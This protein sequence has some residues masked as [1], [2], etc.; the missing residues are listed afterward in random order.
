MRVLITIFFLSL[1][2]TKG[3]CGDDGGSGGDVYGK[4]F[5][6]LGREFSKVIK[7]F[8]GSA[9]LRKW[10]VDADLFLAA[11]EATLL[12]SDEGE[13]VVLKGKEVDA[14]K[15]PEKKSI[16]INRTRWRGMSLLKRM[17]MVVHEYLGILGKEVNQYAVSNEFSDFIILAYR[18]IKDHPLLEVDLHYGYRRLETTFHARNKICDPSVPDFQMLLKEAEQEAISRCQLY[19]EE[20]ECELRM[21][22]T[23]EVISV[24][25][26]GYRYCEITIIAK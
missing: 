20:A 5:E 13:N 19:N 24:K 21:T 15:N 10:E 16:L 4:E 23:R 7:E 3:Y 17:E 22:E 9:I 11:I 18:K 1:I 2:L 6:L 8:D 12:R 25:L 14:I 26:I